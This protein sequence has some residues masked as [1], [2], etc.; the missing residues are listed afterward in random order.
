MKKEEVKMIKYTTEDGKEFYDLNQA[1]EHEKNLMFE[2]LKLKSTK[3]SE[4]LIFKIDNLD[5]L[6][7]LMSNECGVKHLRFNID[8]L[9][10]PTYIC[11]SIDDRCHCEVFQ[12]LDDV[13]DDVERILH[14]LKNLK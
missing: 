6:K 9:V 12:L 1:N 10:Y 11:K 8:N 14:K 7:L 4:Y 2:K 13:I 3:I 5:E